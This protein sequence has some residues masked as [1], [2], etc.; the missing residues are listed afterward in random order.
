MEQGQLF[1]ILLASNHKEAIVI[2]VEDFSHNSVFYLSDLV[3]Q[4]L[5]LIAAFLMFYNHHVIFFFVTENNFV[6][7]LGKL[8]DYFVFDFAV[9]HVFGIVNKSLVLLVDI[10]IFENIYLLFV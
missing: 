4:A 5:C 6:K 1:V 7:I 2:I 10:V 9:F 3:Y 8:Y